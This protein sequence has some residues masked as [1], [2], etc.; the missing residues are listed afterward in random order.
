MAVESAD[1]V[2]APANGSMSL[3]FYCC[4]FPK[5]ASAGG[6]TVLKVEITMSEKKQKIV[7]TAEEK[8][9]RE[10]ETNKKAVTK[11][12]AKFHRIN[13]RFTKEEFPQIKKAAEI[14]GVSVGKFV[15]DAALKRA[16]NYR[17]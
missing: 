3:C 2:W 16:N 10:R 14:E 5:D 17:H 6:M 1:I 8:K 11:Y 13:C 15:S 12:A 4:T 9:E 7:L